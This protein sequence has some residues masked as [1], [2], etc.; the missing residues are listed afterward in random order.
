MSTKYLRFH[1]ATQFEHEVQFGTSVFALVITSILLFACFFYNCGC[2]KNCIKCPCCPTYNNYYY[3][4]EV[5]TIAEEKDSI[6][7]ED[8]ADEADEDEGG[9]VVIDNGVENSEED[10]G[11]FIV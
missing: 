6:E 7:N 10:F 5:P 2:F 4:H 9:D 11:S 3:N 8:E 1:N